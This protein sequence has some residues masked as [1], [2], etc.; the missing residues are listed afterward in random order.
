MTLGKINVE[1]TIAK[2]NDL[3]QKEKN[4]SPTLRSVIEVLLILITLLLQRKGLNSRNSSKPPSDDK[5][6][7]RGCS[8][9]KSKRSPGGQNGRKGIQLKQVSNPDKIK[10]LKLD[11]RKL[12]ND[13]YKEIGYNKR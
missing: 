1:Q 2:A 3:L 4:I 8:K 6:R 7:K 9:P 10:K 13:T 12:P 5:N 11:K